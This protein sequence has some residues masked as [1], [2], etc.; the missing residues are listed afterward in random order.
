[1]LLHDK[2]EHHK[3]V[4]DFFFFFLRL[5]KWN[6]VLNIFESWIVADAP[7]AEIWPFLTNCLILLSSFCHESISYFS[8][9]N[10]ILCKQLQGIIPV[11]Q[12]IL[13]HH[14]LFILNR[15]VSLFSSFMKVILWLLLLPSGHLE[16]IPILYGTCSSF[17]TMP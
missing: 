6:K 9:S 2:H 1:M 8:F 14:G 11:I 3:F 17:D 10:M 12:R 7:N 5:L 4:H 16:F 13:G 15:S